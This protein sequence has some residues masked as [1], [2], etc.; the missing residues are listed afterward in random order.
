MLMDR[1][2]SMLV[3]IDIQD[4]LAPAITGIDRVVA[5]TTV[6]LDA[7]RRLEV[8][9]LASEQ[10]PK[11][12]GKTVPTVAELTPPGAIVE[13][14][15]FSAAAN[16]AFSERLAAL[17]RSVPVICGI[18]AHVCVLQTAL[19]LLASGLR[20]VVVRDATGSRATASA[21]AAWQR[22]QQAGIELVTTEMVVFEWLRQA[23]HPAFRELSRLIK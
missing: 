5:N 16:S 1:A 17:E 4:R 3:V 9:I 8:P 15:E 23:D 21:E 10:Y 22:M 20:P 19:D 12:L 14:I 6:L 7:A 13:K 18:E 11:G 2:D